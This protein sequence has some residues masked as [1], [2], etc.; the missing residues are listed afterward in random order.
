MIAAEGHRLSLTIAHAWYESHIVLVEGCLA[1]LPEM[2]CC[3]L[4][5]Q[6]HRAHV[7]AMQEMQDNLP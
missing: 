4:S 7:Y 3:N 1:Y 2:E 6:D 5:A